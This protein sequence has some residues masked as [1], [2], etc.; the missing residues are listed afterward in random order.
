M[1]KLDQL[2]DA[3]R[4]VI[5]AYHGSP[6]PD[7]VLAGG[8]DPQSIGR[9]NGTGEGHGYYFTED[10]DLSQWYGHP[11]E[12][13]IAAPRNA[14]ADW[15]SPVRDQGE[16]LDRFADA[17]SDAP[18]NK[19]KGDAYVEL[20]RRDGQAQLVYQSLLRA[21]NVGQGAERLGR[22]EAGRRASESLSRR[23]VLGGRWQDEWTTAPGMNNYVIFPGAEDAIRVLRKLPLDPAP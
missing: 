2:G 11:I 14:L 22:Y 1:G 9:S 23:G 16:M 10:P 18:E 12:V 7:S 3:V 20:M 8:F 4:Q 15:Y 21:H 13:E 17:L 5:R 6:H 19:W